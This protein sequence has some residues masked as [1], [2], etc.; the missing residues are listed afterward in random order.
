MQTDQLVQSRSGTIPSLKT[1]KVP[2]APVEH[3]LQL[4]NYSHDTSWK[5]G[6]P[7]FIK[8]NEGVPIYKTA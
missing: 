1:Y 3:W 5:D 8:Q 4:A 6:M 2:Y 7:L